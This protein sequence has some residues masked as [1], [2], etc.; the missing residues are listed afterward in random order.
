MDTHKK[1]LDS[2][3]AKCQNGRNMLL[4]SKNKYEKIV[5]YL[6]LGTGASYRFKSWIQR[7]RFQLLQLPDEDQ[8]EVLVVPKEGSTSKGY[9]R[10]LHE[11]Q[12]YGKV[13]DI[14]VYV[15]NHGNYT[16]TLQS[17]SDLY[18]DISKDYISEF[19]KRCD[20][21]QADSTSD[22]ISDS[23]LQTSSKMKASA[24]PIKVIN[25]A[26]S[27]FLQDVSVNI[28]DMR[29]KPSNEFYFIGH[30][31]D[32]F[33]NFSVL[34]PLKNDS[35][36]EIAKNLKRYFLS[37]FGPPKNF[38][39][40]DTPNITKVLDEVSDSCKGS[41]LSFVLDGIKI[42]TQDSETEENDEVA[43]FIHDSICLIAAEGYNEREWSDWLPEIML[44]LNVAR[45]PSAFQDPYTVVFG[46]PALVL[47]EF[48]EFL[49]GRDG[50]DLSAQENPHETMKN[51]ES[52]RPETSNT[53]LRDDPNPLT[54]M[55]Y[56]VHVKQEPASDEESGRAL[57]PTI[58]DRN[59]GE[60]LT[61]SGKRKNLHQG[62]KVTENTSEYS[63]RKTVLSCDN[64]E[65]KQEEYVDN[66]AVP[67]ESSS[68]VPVDSRI[69]DDGSIESPHQNND[70]YNTDVNSHHH[71]QEVGDTRTSVQI[72][73]E[74]LPWLK[75]S[76]RKWHHPRQASKVAASRMDASKTDA[77][78]PHV[79]RRDASK[80]TDSDPSSMEDGVDLMTRYTSG[81]WDETNSVNLG[82]YV[83]IDIA[84]DDDTS[85]DPCAEE[86]GEGY[87]KR[88]PIHPPPKESPEIRKKLTKE[89][90][91][92]IERLKR[93]NPIL[94]LSE[95]RKRLGIER[96][97]EVHVSTVSRAMKRKS[98][99]QEAAFLNSQRNI[100]SICQVE[101]LEEK[102]SQSEHRSNGRHRDSDNSRNKVD[103]MKDRKQWIHKNFLPQDEMFLTYLLNRKPYLTNE[104]VREQL[105]RQRGLLISLHNL[106][107][108]ISAMATHRNIR[109]NPTAQRQGRVDSSRNR[110]ESIV[111]GSPSGAQSSVTLHGQHM[112]L[113][114][115][116]PSVMKKW[117]SRGINDNVTIFGENV[118][119]QATVPQS[120]SSPV[121]NEQLH[122]RHLSRKMRM[123][124]KRNIHDSLVVD[125][126]DSDP[127]V[128][129][130]GRNN[131]SKKFCHAK[132]Q[133]FHAG[134]ESVNQHVTDI[135]V[136]DSMSSGMYD[137]DNE[138]MVQS[139]ITSPEK[140]ELGR[141]Q[142]SFTGYETRNDM[143]HKHGKLQPADLDFLECLKRQ[144][145]CITLT[146][147]KYRLLDERNLDVHVS[148]VCR[149][150][151]KIVHTQEEM[152]PNY[153]VYINSHE[154]GGSAEYQVDNEDDSMLDESQF[155]ECSEAQ[156]A[157]SDECVQSSNSDNFSHRTS[158]DL[159]GNL[160]SGSPDYIL[161]EDA[162]D[163]TYSGNQLKAVVD[164]RMEG[165]W[166]GLEVTNNKKLT[167]KDMQLI[168]QLKT[169]DP[170]I[171][172]R[173]I[174]AWLLKE[175]DKD[176]HL[177]TISR[178]LKKM[179]GSVNHGKTGDVIDLTL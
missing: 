10:V 24:R 50:S 156:V 60:T 74:T 123:P 48:D 179:N 32:Q 155:D 131:Y 46:Q 91:C 107:T 157:Y 27:C 37:Y 104:E 52:N 76:K 168:K 3:L 141:D 111:V 125:L 145:P 83:E 112:M 68:Y 73:P 41:S 151:K 35:S 64:S 153:L 136:N 154:A 130:N 53:S 98:S 49:P 120:K 129:E 100:E 176:V 14:H 26:D 63:V 124:T 137:E 138:L 103:L 79:S 77:S 148:S 38:S 30:V 4:I 174:K 93:E 92:F 115:K 160:Y 12:I 117:T 34:F 18:Y 42:K 89:D 2:I 47:S 165:E 56:H 95:I 173:N 78:V 163:E 166:D 65:I 135:S 8:T 108:K 171:T 17:V 105:E 29:L 94:T 122:S 128:L 23:H 140:K 116:Q 82:H 71:D 28:I 69:E 152:E 9:V 149:A 110:D 170:T 88:K 1:Q 150:L 169:A 44:K 126:S 67:R 39:S 21:C 11:N 85:W 142:G 84:E 178:A 36:R 172:L 90:V 80:T 66:A 87:Q 40:V 177:S 72:P 109:E 147:M 59:I 45:R 118:L 99:V 121:Y 164:V 158:Y 139:N 16:Q 55:P 70:S 106:T 119:K 97:V 134:C 57:F 58:K 133:N 19:V 86:T 20:C 31:E 54:P 96:G 25:K 127:Q 51:T 13:Q 15:L 33:S 22:S 102:A 162:E 144:N 167:L 61:V 114:Q 159:S 7:Q 75:V 161:Q 81:N 146:E 43:T 6:K 62:I 175:N 113:H 143:R 101:Y 132:A 5:Q